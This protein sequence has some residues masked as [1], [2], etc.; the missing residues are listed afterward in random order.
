MPMYFGGQQVAQDVYIHVTAA[1]PAVLTGAYVASSI[2]TDK[3]AAR[4]IKMI[5]HRG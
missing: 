4:R 1:A 2:A 3:I 5:P